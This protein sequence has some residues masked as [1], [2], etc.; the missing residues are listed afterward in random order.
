[1]P[2]LGRETK[3]HSAP[4]SVFGVPTQDCKLSNNCFM[5]ALSPFIDAERHP[6]L[7][8]LHGVS[9]PQTCWSTSHPFPVSTLGIRTPDCA[10]CYKL[11][12]SSQFRADSHFCHR[13]SDL[14][15]NL[16]WCYYPWLLPRR[17]LTAASLHCPAIHGSLQIPPH[18]FTNRKERF[19]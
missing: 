7:S 6:A 9:N 14:L 4:Q 19:K 11:S 2:T 15:Q 3:R 12:L 18:S 17:L 1:M 10:S 8:V 13:G 16:S 5:A